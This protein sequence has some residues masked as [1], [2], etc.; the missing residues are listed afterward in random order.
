MNPHP[1][2]A[3]YGNPRRRIAGPDGVWLQ[4]SP[5]NLMV[6]NSVITVDRLDLDSLR[7]LW[8]ERVMQADGGR[9]YPR[10]TQ[11]VLEV[12]RRAYW[13]ED[14]DFDLAHHIFVPPE[15]AELGT[16]EQLQ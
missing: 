6:I 12:G 10:F 11:R 16:R 2:S 14:A 8:S 4:D 3:A 9:R 1:R 13:Q 15:A 7:D 5:T